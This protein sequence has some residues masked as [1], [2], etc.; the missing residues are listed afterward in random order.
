MKEARKKLVVSLVAQ[1]KR[2]IRVLAT[3]RI[4]VLEQAARRGKVEPGEREHGST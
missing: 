1:L 4:S 3:L 2:I